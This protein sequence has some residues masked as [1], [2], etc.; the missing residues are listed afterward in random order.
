[1]EKYEAMRRLQAA[2]VP[3]GAVLDGKDMHFDPQLKA[4]GLLES[5]QYPA[6]R[7]MGSRRVIVG[8]PWKFSA[9]APSVKGPAPTFGQHNREVLQN[10]LG[11]DES[12]CAQLESAG[13]LVDEPT[14]VR[15]IPDL[16]M[17]ERVKLGRLAYWEPDYKQ[18]LGIA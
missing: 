12:R 17:D 18:K 3:A 1:M 10:I 15:A 11:Y 14:K 4:R 9:V 7:K 13:V 5:V 8:R 6:E 2:G 16:T